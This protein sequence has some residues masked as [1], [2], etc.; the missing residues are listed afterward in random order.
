MVNSM[1]SDTAFAA[2]KLGSFYYAGVH[3][4]KEDRKRA[5]KWLNRASIKLSELDK[6]ERENVCKYLSSLGSSPS[7]STCPLK[8]VPEQIAVSNHSRVTSRKSGNGN[9]HDSTSCV[10]SIGLASATGTSGTISSSSNQS[11]NR[12]STGTREHEH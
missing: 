6:S 4:F 5:E 8:S 12:N 10:S 3:G 11:S 2:Y 1:M 9:D 7:A